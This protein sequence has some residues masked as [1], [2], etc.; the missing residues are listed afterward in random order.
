MYVEKL[1]ASAEDDPLD[2]MSDEDFKEHLKAKGHDFK[3]ASGA[4]ALLARVD[5][6]A[7]QAQRRP[8]QAPAAPAPSTVRRLWAR[9]ALLLAAVLTLLALAGAGLVAYLRRPN[10]E[11]IGP[12]QDWG[13]PKPPPSEVAGRLRD[14]AIGACNGHLWVLCRN[15]LDE[16]QKIDPAGE[17]EERVQKARKQIAYGTDP[18]AKPD[19]GKP[20][21]R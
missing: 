12:D 1:I 10:I 3:K 4:E 8:G 11:P 16:A 17:N 15:K 19:D 6:R 18:D 7:R 20:H 9:P 21:G 14:E 13:P 2:A 5:A